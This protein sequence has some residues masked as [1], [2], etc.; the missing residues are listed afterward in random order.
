MLLSQPPPAEFL[1]SDLAGASELCSLPT[2][3]DRERVVPK[4][5]GFPMIE[6]QPEP[7]PSLEPDSVHIQLTLRPIPVVHWAIEWSLHPLLPRT[8]VSALRRQST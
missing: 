5:I 3:E 7:E 8:P 2:R 4:P 6:Q 1:F